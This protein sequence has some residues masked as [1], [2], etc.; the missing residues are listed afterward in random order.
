VIQEE[1]RATRSGENEWPGVQRAGFKEGN[2][3]GEATQVGVGGGPG[4]V[5]G[6][7]VGHLRQLFRVQ[8]ADGGIRSSGRGEPLD[9]NLAH[10]ALASVFSVRS[11]VLRASPVPSAPRQAKN[12]LNPFS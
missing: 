10:L 7:E 2:S 9:S 8:A 1:K 5:E 11:V 12:C 3:A 6:R 4:T